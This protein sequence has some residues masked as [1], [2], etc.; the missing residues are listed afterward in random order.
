MTTDTLT[1]PWLERFPN[2]KI[3]EWQDL[4]G[5]QFQ[6]TVIGGTS[7]DRRAF[8]AQLTTGRTAVVHN[9]VTKH[10]G[11]PSSG[12]DQVDGTVTV[13]VTVER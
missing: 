12:G 9:N 3:A 7:A 1:I 2:L 8:E 6:I 11:G 5:E 13:F 10:V 4:G